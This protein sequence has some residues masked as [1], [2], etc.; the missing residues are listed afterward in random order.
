MIDGSA[1]EFLVQLKKLKKL[2]IGTTLLSSDS[3]AKD[4][5]IEALPNLEIQESF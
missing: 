3:A 4:E 1:V 5:L 2:K